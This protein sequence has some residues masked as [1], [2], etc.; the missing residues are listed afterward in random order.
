MKQIKPD[1]LVFYTSAGLEVEFEPVSP[2]VLEESEAGLLSEYKERGEPIDIPTYTVETAG[3]GSQ[4]FEHDEKSLQTDEDKAKWKAYV[5]ANQRLL[6]EQSQ[7]RLEIVLSSLK[8]QLPEDNTWERKFKKW[9]VKV[10]EDPDEKLMFYI[11]REILKTPE[12][13]FTA[14]TQVISTS[15]KGTVSEEAIEA[16]SKSFRDS[17]QKALVEA[18]LEPGTD[19]AGAEDSTEQPG[20]LGTQPSLP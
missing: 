17:I 4:V 20:Q 15:M 14:M 6:A 1:R 2:I 19:S 9:H 16:A 10:P 5:D 8:I 3:G 18:G 13:L 7:L 12:D 11:Q